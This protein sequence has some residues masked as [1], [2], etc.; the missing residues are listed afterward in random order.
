MHLVKQVVFTYRITGYF[1][2]DRDTFQTMRDLRRDVQE[3]LGD[4]PATLTVMRTVQITDTDTSAQS[5]VI[6]RLFN[7]NRNQEFKTVNIAE[8][9][10][11]VIVVRKLW[12]P[13]DVR[14]FLIEK[15]GNTLDFDKTRW[16]ENIPVIFYDVSK[17]EIYGLRKS[18]PGAKPYSDA[19][20]GNPTKYNLRSV[21]CRAVKSNDVI[22]DADLKQIWPVET[23]KTPVEL[24]KLVRRKTQKIYEG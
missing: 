16:K 12:Y 18:N 13:Q 7:S 15:Y 2:C 1:N 6:T 24:A 17:V 10:V 14:N 21:N 5:D 3:L 22:V 11:S 9:E 8:E 4:G 23:N 19:T 20:V